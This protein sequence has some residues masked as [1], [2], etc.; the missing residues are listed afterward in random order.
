MNMKNEYIK[1]RNVLF[2]FFGLMVLVLVPSCS[3]YALSAQEI[4][5]KAEDRNDGETAIADTVMILVDRKNNQRVRQMKRFDKDFG[6]DSRSII[7]FKSPADVRNTSF[8]SFDWNDDA[9]EDDSWLY[10][11][12][13]K[14]VKR[15]ASKDKSGA[16]MGSDFTYADIAG[17]NIDDW[18]Y[19]FDKNPVQLVESKEVWVIIGKPA[20][21][22]LAKVIKET[23]Y[24]K[25]KVWVRKDNFMVVKGKFWEKK[26]KKI[27]YL[28]VNEIRKVEGIWTSFEVRM[29]TTRRGK[30]EHGTIIKTNLIKYNIPLESNMFTTQRMERGI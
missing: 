15:I 26:G 16:F 27:K 12:A 19:Q 22:K 2:I 3:L 28:T 23:G 8:L 10:L 9:K 11:P 24:L 21:K 6:G 30:M 18:E 4:M 17:L 25:A 7:F 13:L 20:K 5:Q 29:I 1:K 14:K